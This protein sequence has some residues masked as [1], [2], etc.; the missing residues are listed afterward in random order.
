[1]FSSSSWLIHIFQ[2][3][4]GHLSSWRGGWVE[5]NILS[6]LLQ[7]GWLDIFKKAE[8][9]ADICDFLENYNKDPL[10]NVSSERIFNQSHKLMPDHFHLQPANLPLFSAPKL[11]EIEKTNIQSIPRKLGRNKIIFRVKKIKETKSTTKTQ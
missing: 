6:S 4:I 10:R 7:N 8:C 2:A 1:M 5:I 11:F 9:R 3:I